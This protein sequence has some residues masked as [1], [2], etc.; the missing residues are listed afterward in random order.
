MLIA[1]V[2]CSVGHFS[3]NSSVAVAWDLF[4]IA[5]SPLLKSCELCPLTWKL[6]VGQW[7]F[8]HSQPFQ[9]PIQYL[10]IA[11]PLVISMFSFIALKKFALDEPSRQFVR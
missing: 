2:V 1:G 3:G 7:A 11:I 6:Q 10:W 8:R 4:A 9:T 5:T